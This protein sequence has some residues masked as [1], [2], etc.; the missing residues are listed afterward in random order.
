MN[1]RDLEYL[2]ALADHRGFRQAAEACNVSQPTLSTQIRKLEGELGVDL[3][4]RIPRNVI[5]TP[6]GA[7]V[8]SRARRILADLQEMRLVAEASRCGRTRLRLGVFP[9]L[10]PY[11]LPHV[12][13]PLMR[14]FPELDLL[15]TEEKS[16]VLREKLASGQLDAVLLADSAK[17]DDFACKPLFE[18]PFLLAVPTA[19][20]LARRNTI[21][22]GD[23]EG[24][25]LMLL[26]EGHC[27]RD[28]GL[29]AARSM[30]A[31]EENALRGTSLETLRQMVAAGVGMTFLPEL[32]CLKDERG[33][34][35][36]RI[37]AFSRSSFRRSIAIYWRS[38]SPLAALIEEVGAIIMREAQALLRPVEDVGW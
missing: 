5:L 9:T 15:L 28:Q 29:S 31:D 1:I 26:D 37:I 4:E 17:G 21:G 24:E 8:V 36:Y 22:P 23:L 20:R 27:L 38:T 11:L 10:G 25:K 35:G 13:Q 34:A 16:G 6:I 30:G 14:R 7:D 2:V 33:D 18:E 12:I 32:A 19:H 3:V